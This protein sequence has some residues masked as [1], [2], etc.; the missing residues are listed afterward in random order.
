MSNKYT[1]DYF[2][3]LIVPGF[4]GSGDS[5]WQTWLEQQLPYARR[6]DGIDWESPQV[7]VWSAQIIRVLESASQPVW[8]VAH[9]FG[10][11]VTIWASQY[12]AHKI[13][14]VFLVAPADPWRFSY[15]GLY[16]QLDTDSSVVSIAE[17]LPK[18]SLHFPSV[19][20]ASTNDPWVKLTAAGF[21]AQ[22]WGSYFINIGNAGHI[23]INSGFG[24][25]PEGLDLLRQFQSIHG[26]LPLGTVGVSNAAMAH[27]SPDLIVR[28]SQPFQTLNQD[29]SQL[30]HS[31]KD[32]FQL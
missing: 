15:G 31:F 24:P 25:W 4:R 11:L 1:S 29:A 16:E 30:I 22:H 6:I 8:I 26:E 17:K 19:V 28:A 7:E 3:T 32:Y 5:H 14:G 9:S 13:A 10:C 27:E 12:I 21:W 18:Y 2:D 20:I 23:N